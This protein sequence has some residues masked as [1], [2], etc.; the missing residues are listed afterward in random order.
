M[1]KRSSLDLRLEGW[2]KGKAVLSNFLLYR[3]VDTPYAP[4]E[5]TYALMLKT[6][7]YDRFLIGKSLIKRYILSSQ[8][9]KAAY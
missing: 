8:T 3:G 5:L 1:I 7:I 9:S 4:L 6:V 2:K